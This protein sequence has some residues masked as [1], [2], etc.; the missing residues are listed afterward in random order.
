[1][2]GQTPQTTYRFAFDIG[3]TFTDFALEVFQ[4]HG[5]QQ[6]FA[7]V[8]TT[9]EAPERAV[10]EGTRRILAQA[11][12]P[13]SALVRVVHGTTLATNAVIERR[14]ARIAFITTDSLPTKPCCV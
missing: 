9:P 10:I 5:V 13:P 14:G 4:G 1:M 2:A 6:Y 3:G 7:K 12:L 8:L 11:G